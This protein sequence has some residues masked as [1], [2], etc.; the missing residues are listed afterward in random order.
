MR[1]AYRL[2][3]FAHSEWVD[4]P[5]HMLVPLMVASIGASAR[6]RA[7]ATQMSGITGGLRLSTGVLRLQ[8]EFGIGPGRVHFTL[9]AALLDDTS[10]A[11]VS[12]REFDQR[13]T[14]ETEDPYGGVTTAN[15]AVE[16]VL[17]E[18]SGY[19]D[20]AVVEWQAAHPANPEVTPRARP[21]P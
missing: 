19:C 17:D 4:T 18:L 11:V 12:W 7:V 6:F 5:A 9:R 16:A 10:G 3:H 14:S 2:E 15:R 20:Q 1:V 13:A 8:Q 21:R